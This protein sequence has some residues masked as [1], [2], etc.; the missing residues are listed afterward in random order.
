MWLFFRKC[1]VFFKSP[2][3]QKKIFQKTILNL[4]FKV[5]AHNIRL[6]WAGILNFK[7]RIVFLEYFFWGD[8]EIWKMNQ[9]FWKKP[10]LM[11]MVSRS[12]IKSLTKNWKLFLCLFN[13]FRKY[14]RNSSPTMARWGQGYMVQKTFWQMGWIGNP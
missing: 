6:L 8:W 9:T 3:L 4:K 11:S 14:M 7:F 13:G 10:P 2:Y 1:D 5:P 12:T